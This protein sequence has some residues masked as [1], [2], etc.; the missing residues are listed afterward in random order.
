[1]FRYRPPG[2]IDDLAGRKN[3]KDFLD[4]WHNWIEGRVR[5][6]IQ[7]VVHP[8]KGKDGRRDHP[9]PHPLFFCEVDH[10]SSDTAG[11]PWNGFPL[12]VS[13]KYRQN[14]DAGLAWVD[15]LDAISDDTYTPEGAPL[16]TPKYR[17]QDEYCEW[18]FYKDGPLG[19]RIVFTA[20]G[21]E[22]WIKL[23]AYDFDKVVEL[24]QH[25]VSPDVKKD[26]LRLQRDMRY[27]GIGVLKAGSYDPFNVWNT[28]KGVMHL[29]HYANTLGAEINLAARATVLRR[30]GT[31]A[32]ISDSRRL[33]ASSGYGSVNRSSDPNIGH[34]V[35]IT[36]V[37]A[38]SNKPLSITLANPVGLYMDDLIA[39]NSIADKDDQPLNGW[40]NFVRGAKGHGLMAVFEPPAG[41]ARTLE[42]VFV[43]GKKLTSGGQIARHIQMIVYAATADLGAPMSPLHPPFLRA[44]VPVGTDVSDLTNVNILPGFSADQTCRAQGPVG[45]PP[46]DIDEAYPGLYPAPQGAPLAAVEALHV[47]SFAGGV[48]RKSMTRDG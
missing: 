18:H 29:T 1:M 22:Y 3:Q 21:P 46:F 23:A 6:E 24:Y 32:R 27:D 48:V 4:D 28:D 13:R 15:E 17:R 14:P 26:D 40:F 7:G 39:P 43:D 34:G 30:D 12:A 33:I 47:S 11:V 41:D 5:D 38:G 36:A 8:P 2:D 44:C 9:V 37:P 35:N 19:P 31:G 20:E 16:V 25:W 42:D 45:N 10:Q